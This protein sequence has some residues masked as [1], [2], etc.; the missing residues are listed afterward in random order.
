MKKLR[1][2]VVLSFLVGLFF[3][4]CIKDDLVFDV[5]EFFVLV[6]F[7][8]MGD[9]VNNLMVKVIFYDLDKS[10]ILDNVVGIDL[11]F[12]VNLEIFV[13]IFVNQLV[14][15]FIIDSN[16]EVVFDVLFF[17]LIGVSCLEWVGKYD[18]IDFRIFYNF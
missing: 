8:D 11:I 6:V 16:G 7:E 2:S 5:I 13:F 1:Y 15:I 18:D 9:G 4:F 10:G 14:E 3:F 12:V 17:N